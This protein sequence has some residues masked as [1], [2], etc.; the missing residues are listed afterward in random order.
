M[1]GN[2]APVPDCEDEEVAKALIRRRGK[3]RST[4]APEAISPTLHVNCSLR[5]KMCR[6]VPTVDLDLR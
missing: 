2:Y 5:L 4:G 6:N 3:F 1:E